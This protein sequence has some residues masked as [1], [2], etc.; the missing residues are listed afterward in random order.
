MSRLF[1]LIYSFWSGLS[2]QSIFCTFV[3]RLE[4]CLVHPCFLQ[5]L[6]LTTDIS[7]LQLFFLSNGFFHSILVDFVFETLLI[8]HLLFLNLTLENLL[9]KAFPLICNFV[10]VNILQIIGCHFLRAKCC[11][12]LF[13]FLF[14]FIGFLFILLYNLYVKM[15]RLD[16]SQICH[17]LLLSG[18][19]LLVF[20]C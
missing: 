4:L 5:E 10:L 17:C 16:L 12:L 20:R 19:L 6:S 8:F 11:C 1:W 3:L 15:L 14:F 2:K 18:F 13:P 9:I 7:L